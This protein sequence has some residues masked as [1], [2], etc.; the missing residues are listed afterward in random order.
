MDAKLGIAQWSKR[1]IPKIHRAQRVR[2]QS[3][4]TCTH[5]QR[6]LMAWGRF[7]ATVISSS[8]KQGVPRGEGVVKQRILKLPI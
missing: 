2:R 6:H 4:Q 7:D 3:A 5:S 8:V 1:V